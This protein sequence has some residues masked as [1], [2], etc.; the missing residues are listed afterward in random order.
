MPPR[1]PPPGFP[2]YGCA[3]LVRFD[4][5]SDVEKD[6]RQHLFWTVCLLLRGVLAACSTLAGLERCAPVEFVLAGYAAWWGLNLLKNF[7]TQLLRPDPE[8]RGNF[9]GRVWWQPMRLVHGALLCAYAATTFARVWWAFAFALA[10]VGMAVGAGV[11]Y[12]GFLM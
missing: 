5:D 3:H 7:A 2:P 6:K 12:Y 8:E 4:P 1:P 11:V 10:D 9:K